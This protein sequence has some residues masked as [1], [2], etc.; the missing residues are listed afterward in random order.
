MCGIIGFLGSKDVQPILLSGLKK[1]EYRGY[2]S[3][4]VAVLG[5]EGLSIDKKAGKIS[6]LEDRLKHNPLQGSLGIGHTRWATHGPPTRKNAHP[7]Q[8]CENAIALVHNGIIENYRPLKKELL[9]RGH[10][11]TS[12]TDTEV[13]AHLIEEEEG[14]LKERVRNALSRVEGSYALAVVSVE[15]PD[16]IV[17]A[18]QG[19]PLVMGTKQ[20]DSTGMLASDIPAIL[21]Y[22][23]DVIFLQDEQIARIEKGEIEVTDF[24]G[25]P[26]DPERR[27]IDWDPISAQKDGYKHF[28][29]KEIHEQPRSVGDTIRGEE[30]SLSL[31]EG[32]IKPEE[33]NEINKIFILA[34]GTSYYAG[35]VAKYIWGEFLDLPIEVELGS[36]FRYRASAVDER[37]LT[38]GISQSGE[39]ADTLAAL[40]KARDAGST[41]ISVPNVLG[42]SITR[43]SDA[44]FYIR[45]GPEIG[46]ASTK[47]FTSQLAALIQLGC[48][49][50][51]LRGELGE[52]RKREILEELSRAPNL[53]REILEREGEVESLAEK[54]FRKDNFLYLG[55]NVLYPVALEGALKLK[56]ISYIHAEGYP[57]GEM[58]HGP[59]ALIDEDMPVVGLITQNS[60]YDKI[61][62][63]IEEVKAR[64]GE[65]IIFTDLLTE[66][67]E[68]VADH[69]F[70]LPETGL[71]LVPILFVIPLQ[72]LSYHIGVL[73][74]TDVDQPRNLAKSVTVE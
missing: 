48:R 7:H 29:A 12:Q 18:R 62:S 61:F 33:I 27:H 38:I 58:K 2:D 72:L 59:I 54:F 1:L 8:G 64:K 20:G 43:K 41:V 42:S 65:V 70:E 15:E 25:D 19:S 11:L 51:S 44:V 73:R 68:S 24:R 35:M 21:D 74:G 63:N 16:K 31:D 30:E 57:A 53:I 4:G 40:E 36:E 56:E 39:T 60:V 10:E 17:A 46:V 3:A 32:E 23:R 14:P 26:V 55:R 47:A 6:N 13:L 69:V 49:L 34:C 67:I 9:S 22:T 5:E 45:A 37:S 50:G 71:G 28:M 52:E 66:E